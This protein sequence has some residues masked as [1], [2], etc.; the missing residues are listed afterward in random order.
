[1]ENVKC[2][3][4]VAQATSAIQKLRELKDDGF[5]A[6]ESAILAISSV[7]E[8]LSNLDSF[9][10]DMKKNPDVTT[11]NLNEFPN[12][13]AQSEVVAQSAVSL[14]LA[15]DLKEMDSEIAHLKNVDYT[16]NLDVSKAKTLEQ[17]SSPLKKLGSI[18]DDKINLVEK[19][20]ALE[21]LVSQP[22]IDPTVKT[23][24]EKAKQSLD[25]LASFDLGFAV[26][27]SEF[28]KA[29]SAFKALHDFLVGFLKIKQKNFRWHRKIP[30]GIGRDKQRGM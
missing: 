24:L 27:Q 12:S 30:F 4:E 26:H 18:P 2:A 28:Q 21:F 7:S 5:E 6:L 14:R 17:F 29:P 9:T 13:A 1:M 23:E 20:K 16:S 8:D 19:S 11:T 25:K 10:A 22:Q 15:R 3:E